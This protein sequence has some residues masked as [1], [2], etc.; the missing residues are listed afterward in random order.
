MGTDIAIANRIAKE[1][2]VKLEMLRHYDSYEDVVRAVAGGE[3]DLGISDLTPTFARQQIVL[4]SDPYATFS[5]AVLCN[6][7]KMVQKDI[8]IE[9]HA[10]FDEFC[11][12]FNNPSLTIAVEG[13]TSQYDQ[14]QK[15]FPKA[16]VKSYPDFK[17]ALKDTR[18]GQADLCLNTDFDI[19]FVKLFDPELGFYCSMVRV[20]DMKDPICVAVSPAC[21]DMLGLVNEVVKFYTLGNAADTI[22]KY[23]SFLKNMEKA[24]RR[25]SSSSSNRAYPFDT[26]YFG[27]EQT[28]TALAWKQI[29]S[30]AGVALPL[31][32]FS[33]LWIRMSHRRKRE[34]P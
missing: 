11:A 30:S 28:A 21:G 7:E 29:I 32:I 27:N 8:R 19:L 15:M 33:V 24:R 34:I 22:R 16:H 13:G 26:G 23:R 10:T 12:A 25:D 14:A 2:G 3:A 17:A 9:P 1:L 18:Y 20:P 6:R 31:V 4:F 5:L